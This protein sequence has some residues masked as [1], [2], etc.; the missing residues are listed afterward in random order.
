MM[1]VPRSCNLPPTFV[2]AT[3]FLN[4]SRYGEHDEQDPPRGNVSRAKE[5]KYMKSFSGVGN[6]TL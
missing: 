2:P 6:P 3:L 5:K 1:F 4:S